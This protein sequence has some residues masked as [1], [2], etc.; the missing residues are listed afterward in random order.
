MWNFPDLIE[1]TLKKV[2]GR[3]LIYQLSNDE[4]PGNLG[5]LLTEFHLAIITQH[6]YNKIV[7]PFYK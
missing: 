2:D 6:V 4:C 5:T 7:S 3:L 1:I